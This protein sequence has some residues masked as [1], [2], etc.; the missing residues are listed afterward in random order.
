MKIYEAWTNLIDSFTNE[1]M[2]LSFWNE[3]YVA[4][5]EVYKKI[6]ASGEYKLAGTAA[7]IAEKYGMEPVMLGGFLDG[8]NTSFV[9]A[10]DLETIEDTTVIEAVF[11]TVDNFFYH[12]MLMIYCY[13]VFLQ[14]FNRMFG[15][16]SMRSI[17]YIR[18]NT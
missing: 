12:G 18:P 5:T 6:L 2:Q 8:A 4:E 11:D 1:Q 16:Y 3:Y 14:I 13:F 10:L 9:E 15:I 17:V 7:E